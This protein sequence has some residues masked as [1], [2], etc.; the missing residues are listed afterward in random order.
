MKNPSLKNF[1]FVYLHM[2]SCFLYF[3][4]CINVGVDDANLVIFLVESGRIV[5]EYLKCCQ[6]VYPI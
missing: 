6:E 3:F 5:V 1:Y 2:I 4:Y